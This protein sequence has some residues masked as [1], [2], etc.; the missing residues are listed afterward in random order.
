M[1]NIKYKQAVK[2]FLKYLIAERGYSELTIKEYELDLNVFARYLKKEF[3]CS[4]KK[5]TIDD[6]NEFQISEFLGDIILIKDNSAATRNRKLYS[7]RSFFK[8]LKKKNLIEKNPVDSIEPTK[9]KLKSE[10]IYLSYKEIKE[11]LKAIKNYDSKNKNR[12]IAIIKTFLYCGLRISELVSLNVNDINYQDQSIKF[13]GKGN[14]ERYVPLHQ[15]VIAAIKNYLPDRK[16]I[17]PSN[18]DAKEALFLSNR[19][20]RISTRTVQKMVKKYAKKAGIKNANQIT[21][22]KLRHTFAS[23][24]YRKTKDLRVL[25]ELLGHSDISTTQIYTHTDKEQRKNAVQQM[26][27]L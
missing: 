23:I 2:S 6:I 12:D 21:P 13:Y 7:L 22:H 17:T 19:G 20:N 26:P 16:Q 3:D 4:E 8:F 24:L 10:P 15:E 25:Q 5:L 14:K 11:Y 27:E 1:K 9:T 18:A